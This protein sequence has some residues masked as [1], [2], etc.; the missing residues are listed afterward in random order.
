MVSDA[1]RSKRLRSPDRCLTLESNGAFV[2]TLHGTSPWEIV[3]GPIGIVVAGRAAGSRCRV[4]LQG[5]TAS[6]PG[7]ACSLS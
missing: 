3:L 2:Q 7:L 5:C 6:E 4:A 1:A